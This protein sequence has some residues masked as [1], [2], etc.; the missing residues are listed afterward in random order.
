MN[1]KYNLIKRYFLSQINLI[2]FC[3]EGETR[4]KAT[5]IDFADISVLLLLLLLLLLLMP[6]LTR[7]LKRSMFFTVKG[8]DIV[9]EILGTQDSTEEKRVL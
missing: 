2:L 4:L 3:F 5:I 6:L 8:K 1:D 9:Y 7:S